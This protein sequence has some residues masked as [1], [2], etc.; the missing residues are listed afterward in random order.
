MLLATLLTVSLAA[1]PL[2]RVHVDPERGIGADDVPARAALPG[3]DG[4]VEIRVRGQWSRTLPKKSYAVELQDAEGENLDA[5][6]L[7]M[8][9]DDD[10][11]L[12]A[13]Y[14]DRTLIRNVLAYE[15]AR[16]LG[17]YA[18][19]TRFVELVIRGR[20]RGVY[21]LM[22]K[23][24][25]HD[26]RV[27]GKFL[28]ELTSRR[29]AER[30]DPHF[31]TPVTRRPIVWEDPEREDLSREQARGIARRVGA[32]ERALYRGRAGAWRRH[33]HARSAVDY[34]LLTEL[35]KNADGM[36]ASTFMSGSPGA[37]LRLGPLWDLDMSMGQGREPLM[38]RSSGWILRNRPWSEPLY[39]DASFRR[40]MAARWRGL[41]ADGLR[42]RLMSR[43][44]AHERRLRPA[45]R[46][47]ARRWGAGRD[48]PRGTHRGHTRRMERWL[49]RRI[50]WIDRNVGR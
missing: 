6:L 45:A 39:R 37:K 21:V 38:R 11:V 43:I 9:A 19:R 8:P 28:L 47:D 5:P 32:A 46:Q 15:T 22:E 42:A 10:W 41:R 4:R 3:Y 27:R 36:H 35:F 29:Q 24:K 44:A 34:L 2:P 33:L 23:P 48:R 1:A 40:A 12:Y 25:L 49:E 13:A 7:G 31:L 20:T 26:A 18:A 30:K 50:A 16:G 17:A 14:N